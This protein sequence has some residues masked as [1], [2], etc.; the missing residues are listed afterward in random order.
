MIVSLG[1]TDNILVWAQIK[2]V[3]IGNVRQILGKIR[4]VG[5]GLM[6]FCIDV[7]PYLSVV[8]EI[9]VF[10]RYLPEAAVPAANLQKS[11]GSKR[12]AGDDGQSLAYPVLPV[13]AIAYFGRFF[14]S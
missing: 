11:G 7:S 3:N 6:N 4:G 1:Y 8:Y 2:N 5:K 14:R 12:S 9:I 10:E 13:N